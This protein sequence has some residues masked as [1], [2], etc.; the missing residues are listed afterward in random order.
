MFI[1]LPGPRGTAPRVL[2]ATAL[3]LGALSSGPALSADAPRAAPRAA[4]PGPAPGDA[5][6][7]IRPL[8]HRSHLQARP[9][10][11]EVEPADWPGVNRRVQAAGG[12]KA[13]AREAQAPE[14]RP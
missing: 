4:P 6:A 13:Y 10:P 3:M 2:L 1:D 12:W 14:A 11:T 5:D 8:V 9:A 7:P